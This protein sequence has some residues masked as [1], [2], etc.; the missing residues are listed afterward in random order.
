ME[1]KVLNKK[2]VF[3]FLVE[4]YKIVKE[5]SRLNIEAVTLEEAIAIS[6][7]K[8]VNVNGTFLIEYI[9]PEKFNNK[10]TYIIKYN[11]KVVAQNVKI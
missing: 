2:K 1:I 9:S 5:E 4:K 6:T 7:Q 11:D 10:S 8:T 3:K